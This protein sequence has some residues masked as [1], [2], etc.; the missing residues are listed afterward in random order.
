MVRSRAARR[1]RSTAG[2]GSTSTSGRAPRPH[3]ERRARARALRARARLRGA[4]YRALHVAEAAH[5]P[6]LLPAL[7]QGGRAGCDLPDPGRPHR[8]ALSLGDRAP[9]LHRRAGARFSRAAHRVRPRRL[10]VDRGDDRR[11]LEAPERVDRHLGTR[12]EALPAG[13]R[14]LHENLRQGQGLLRH[15]LPAAPVGARA[16]RGRVARPVARGP[17]EVPA[18]QRRARVPAPRV[19]HGRMRVRRLLALLVV[20]TS[21]IDARGAALVIRN[22]RLVDGTGP[23]ARDGLS[24]L[25]R[26]GRIAAIAPDVAADDATLLDVA[27]ATVLPGLMDAIG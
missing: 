19:A 7:R 12:A 1:G 25:V 16:R 20:A 23:P 14:P 5:R 21:A 8:A 13:L 18:R 11:R 2:A 22:A 6:R 9:A 24:I 27:G 26:D 17:A 15:R 3:H 4:A 10:A